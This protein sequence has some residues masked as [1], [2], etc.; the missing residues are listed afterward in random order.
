MPLP[1]QT[2]SELWAREKKELEIQLGWVKGN[3][4]LSKEFQGQ[5]QLRDKI[6][7]AYAAGFKWGWGKAVEACEG[8][9]RIKEK[10]KER[11]RHK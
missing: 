6:L 11:G 2:L 4:A 10:E 9:K 7:E 8:E 1:P 3:L 5:P